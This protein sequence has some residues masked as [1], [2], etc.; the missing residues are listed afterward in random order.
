M[1]EKQTRVDVNKIK[2]IRKKL[3]DILKEDRYDIP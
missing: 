2:R 3:K 1:E